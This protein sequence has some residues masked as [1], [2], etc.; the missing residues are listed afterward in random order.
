VAAE[1]ENE[2]GRAVVAPTDVSEPEAVDRLIATAW[3]RWAA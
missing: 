1:I 3:M 2:G